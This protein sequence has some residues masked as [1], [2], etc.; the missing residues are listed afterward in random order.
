[1]QG[2]VDFVAAASGYANSGFAEVGQAV[3]KFALG[4]ALRGNSWQ[5]DHEAKSAGL[6]AGNLAN[7]AIGV[8]RVAIQLEEEE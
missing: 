5:S 4:F 8:L 2:R 1:V 6:V 7:C 3:V